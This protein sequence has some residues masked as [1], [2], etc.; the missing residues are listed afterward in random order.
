M[1]LLS[2]SSSSKWILMSNIYSFYKSSSV[3]NISKEHSIR[4]KAFEKGMKR[5]IFTCHT[6]NETE[7]VSNAKSDMTRD[8]ACI[9]THTD[10]HNITK[11]QP[12]SVYI[13]K[14]T[15]ELNEITKTNQWFDSIARVKRFNM[16]HYMNKNDTI[17]CDSRWYQSLIQIF[18]VPHQFNH[19]Q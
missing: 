10:T 4:L 15:F 19:G 9:Y 13:R 8:M 14:N 1:P 5:D 7:I 12:Q 3:L 11:H 18:V 17:D 2:C 16:I 6:V